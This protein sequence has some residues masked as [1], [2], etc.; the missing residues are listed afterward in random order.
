MNNKQ[1]KALYESIMKSVAKSVKKSINEKY[2]QESGSYYTT[3]TN[4]ESLVI[5]D[6]CY[7][8][9]DDIYNNVWGKA[10]YA[11]GI[12]EK[13]DEIVGIV[14]STGYGDGTYDSMTDQEYDVD[15]GALGIF[16]IAFCKPGIE[17]EGS[18]QVIPVGEDEDIED[19]DNEIDV[20]LDYSNSVIT[21]KINQVT[22][23]EIYLT[24]TD[25]D[26][27]E[28]ADEWDEDD[29]DEDDDY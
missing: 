1:K 23:E 12:I 10:K 22:E 7:C 26:E 25:D 16:D 6:P 18:V 29:W 8:L 3:M 4:V 20:E 28:D 2:S 17:S 5:G 24:D 27:E 13:D 21:F 11:N 19:E 14:Q 15:S 9:T